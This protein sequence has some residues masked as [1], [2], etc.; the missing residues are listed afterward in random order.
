MVWMCRKRACILGTFALLP[1][2]CVATAVEALDFDVDTANPLHLVRGSLKSPDLVL[3]NL[4][5]ETR[6]WKGVVRYRDHFGRG[7]DREV[8]VAAEGGATVRVAPDRDLPAKGIWYV[9]ADLVGD[10]GQK[11]I[12]ETRFA[13]IDRHDATPTLPKPFFRMGINFHAQKY[14]NTSKFGNALDALVASGAK[15]VRSGGFKFA[16]NAKSPG[17]YDWSMTDALVEA[18]RSR[19]LA[20]NANVYPGPPWARREPTEE[21]M[22]EPVGKRMARL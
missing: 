1:F 10:D 6:R 4:S 11:G 12:V 9:T 19:G 5:R 17:K 18:F 22:K 2:L 8:D 13:A 14:W 16:E 3:S 15:L 20:I 7:F 21:Q